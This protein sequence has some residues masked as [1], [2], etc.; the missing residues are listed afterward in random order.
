[1][2]K[3]TL[4]C[5]SHRENGLCTA[6]ELLRLLRAIDP[7]VIF[8]EVPQSDIDFYNPRS[9][10]GQ[11]VTRFLTFKSFQRIPVD[12]YEVPPNFRALTDSVLDVV[13][14]TSNEYRLLQEQQDNA[15]QLNGLTYLN[16]AAFANIMAR[17][18]A[19]ED[20]TINSA[21]NPELVSALATWRQVMQGRE[22][23][24]LDNI[25]RYCRENV[26]DIGVFLVGAAHRSGIVKAI[27]ELLPADAELIEWNLYLS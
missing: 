2:R 14:Q 11:A 12:R 22:K 13:E 15:T 20:Q 27:E 1:M 19:I 23:A 4:V 17:M 16:S 21:G 8:G 25:Y 9:L 6:R 26:F 18:S 7:E 5:S 24:M 3:I 10:E